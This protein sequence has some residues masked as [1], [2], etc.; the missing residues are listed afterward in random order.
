MR[1]T[2]LSADVVVRQVPGGIALLDVGQT[3]NLRRNVCAP[4]LALAVLKVRTLF[5]W[6][7]PTYSACLGKYHYRHFRICIPAGQST[8]GPKLTTVMIGGCAPAGAPG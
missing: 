3:Y 7:G 5:R 6:A 2:E 1:T 4:G 8:A